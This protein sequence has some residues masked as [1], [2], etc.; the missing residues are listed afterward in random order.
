MESTVFGL[1][2]LSWIRL[3]MNAIDAFVGLIG[4]VSLFAMVVIS[5]YYD[6]K[7]RDK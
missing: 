6:Y 1:S 2:L 7:K 3:G 4:I 5:V